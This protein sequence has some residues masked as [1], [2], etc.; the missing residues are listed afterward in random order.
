MNSHILPDEIVTAL[1][2]AGR[3]LSNIRKAESRKQWQL[4]RLVNDVWESLP[5]D[6]REEVRKEDYY[7]ECSQWINYGLEFPVVGNS[8]QTLRRWADVEKQFRAFPNNEYLSF[9]HFEQ[10]RTIG[11]NPLSDVTATEALALAIRHGWTADEMRAELDKRHELDPS[12]LEIRK[13]WPLF[14]RFADI[15][16]TLNGSRKQ[17]EYHMRE[18]TRLVE[19]EMT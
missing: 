8:G 9:H 16:I 12:V 17:V 19:S 1:R 10:A 2:Q 13:S 6:I 15:L 3:R 5:N 4:G 7:A 14:G 11:G 18:I